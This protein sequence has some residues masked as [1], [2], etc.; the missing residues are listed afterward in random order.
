MGLKEGALR[1][2]G[3][4]ARKPGVA[5]D[6]SRPPKSKAPKG[7]GKGVA[8]PHVWIVGQDHYKHQMYHPWQL[9]KAQANFRKE[10]WDLSFEDYYQI[11]NGLWDQRGRLSDDLCMTRID[12][13][14]PWIKTNITIITRREHCQKQKAYQHAMGYFRNYKRRGPD[15]RPRKSKGI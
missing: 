13:E 7:F 1:K 8:R 10:E 11:W 3:T 6:P 12:Y 5:P 15:T 9:A 4:P 2:N 14:G